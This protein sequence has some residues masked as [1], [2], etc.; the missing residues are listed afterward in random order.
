MRTW[1][2]LLLLG[3]GYLAHA[4]AEEAEIP[5]EVIERLARSQIYS[6][7]D[8]QRLLEIDSVGAE[9][10]LEASLRAHGGHA[11]KHA[12][13]KRPMPIRRKRSIEEA[14]PA[15]CKTRTV[16]YEI[17]RSQVDP[18]SANFL[19]WPPCV[20]VKRC[21]GCCNTSSV[22][23][24]PSRVHHRSVKV[25]PGP[26]PA[27][28]APRGRRTPGPGCRQGGGRAG[29][30]ASD[31]LPR[32]CMRPP[33][34][35]GHAK[36]LR[37][38]AV[39]VLPAVSSKPWRVL[40]DT[41]A[42][43]GVLSEPLPRS[44]RET[45]GGAGVGAG[46]ATLGLCP[47]SVSQGGHPALLWGVC[48]WTRPEGPP[49]G[50]SVLGAG[51]AKPAPLL[52]LGSCALLGD[53]AVSGSWHTAGR[54]PQSPLRG[55]ALPLVTSRAVPG[56]RKVTFRLH[57]GVLLVLSALVLGEICFFSSPRAATLGLG[58]TLVF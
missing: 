58:Q 26:G 43:S 57:V 24:Q 31:S 3:C 52:V 36:D 15:V 21:A 50:A 40:A 19:I 14:I 11:S 44:T 18:T 47:L 34:G 35:S 17:P 39:C 4:L 23:C 33:P 28:G 38:R 48:P 45:G 13:E 12:P 7:R 6:I 29:T 8:L 1:A 51:A 55:R 9:D 20:E 46:P 56:H 22:K 10:A 2:C 30:W 49:G 37:T 5:R 27:P 41:S 32:P 42:G 25:S 53:P 16:I 54:L